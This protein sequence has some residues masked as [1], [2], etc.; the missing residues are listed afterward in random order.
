M[1][2]VRPRR[3][4]Q[5]EERLRDREGQAARRQKTVTNRGLI[6]ED[7]DLPHLVISHTCSEMGSGHP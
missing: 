2:E 5:D 6:L 1:S 4:H 3:T 7:R